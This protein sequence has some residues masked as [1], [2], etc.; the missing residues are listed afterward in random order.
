MNGYAGI[1]ERTMNDPK[2]ADSYKQRLKSAKE[3]S[4][5]AKKL[6][7]DARCGMGQSAKEQGLER[8]TDDFQDMLEERAK[9]DADGDLLQEI[10]ELNATLNRMYKAQTTDPNQ[11]R[12][13][14]VVQQTLGKI[15]AG[16]KAQAQAAEVLGK[17][18]KFIPK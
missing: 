16:R 12:I 5:F 17:P 9:K 6:D 10:R 14:A 18:E 11:A 8:Y 15:E 1:Y 3:R 4:D 2:F 7:E 13:D